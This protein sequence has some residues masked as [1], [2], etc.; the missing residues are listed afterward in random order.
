MT[1]QSLHQNE[2]LEHDDAE[3]KWQKHVIVGI[4]VLV[5]IVVAIAVA[6]A[7]AEGHGFL[8]KSPLPKE[9]VPAWPSEAP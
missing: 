7:Y 9:P 4:W 3:S 1:T 6:L 2:F 8:Q 5:A